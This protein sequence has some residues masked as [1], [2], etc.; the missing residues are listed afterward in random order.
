MADEIVTR[1][2]LVDAGLDAESLQTFISGSDIEDVLTRLGKIYPT[3]AKLI[4][5]LMETGGW[6]AYETEAI[7]LAATPLVNPSV[8]YAFDTKKLYLWNGTIWKD[9]GLS[10][11]DL[12][13]E[14]ANANP[15]FKPVNLTADIDLNTIKKSGIYLAQNTVPSLA[16]NYPTT[17]AGTFLAYEVYTGTTGTLIPQIYI[18]FDG[19]MYA[20]GTTDI[21][22]NVYTSWRKVGQNDP[23]VLPNNTDIRTITKTGL[24]LIYSDPTT[25]TTTSNLP[26]AGEQYYV[27][28][29]YSTS[30]R[31]MVAYSRSGNDVYIAWYWG[32][33]GW[34]AWDRLVTEKDIDSL[35]TPHISYLFHSDLMNPFKETRIKLIGDSITWG[36][37]GSAGGPTTPRNGD[38]NDVRNPIDTSISKTWANLFR[39]W[40]AKTYGDTTVTQDKPG[41]GF[42]V[43]KIR[44]TWSDTYKIVKMTDRT[45][46]IL[47]DA[48]KLSYIVY[49]SEFTLKFHGSSIRLVNPVVV[50]PRPT[51]ME[52][53]FYGDNIAI[54]YET[55]PEGDAA[56]IVQVYL[57]GNLHGTFN[58]FSATAADATYSLTTTS[59]QHTLKLKNIATNVNSYTN[60]YGFTIDKK[61]YV[62]NDGIIGTSTKNWIDKSL[63]EGSLHPK[64]DFVFHMLGT[65]DRATGGSLDGYKRRIRVGMDKIKT[66]APNAKIILMA[67]TY[68]DNESEGTYKF[69]MKQVS[70]VNAVLAKEM[71]VPFIDHYKYCAQHILDGEVI[72][73]DGTHLNDLG[74]R[75]F[76]QNILREIFKI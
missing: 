4:R 31:R 55:R 75:L 1:Q 5:I 57:D 3:L 70:D 60:I 43:N 69:H 63:Y 58:Y 67:S 35:K 71:N 54:D 73:S 44:T 16:K 20:R 27:N 52:V 15:L 8:G 53:S 9:E 45:G 2:Q 46:S 62:G 6:K 74:N 19:E 66:L 51:E 76:F 28:V 26:K 41:S 37:G 7:L 23:E 61:I 49:D 12:A 72:L 48:L 38:L 10:P 56:D 64:D 25:P 18:T 17:K 14:F 30:V 68:A 24:Y 36:M 29:M 65:N 42:T 47:S 32:T 13:K 39:T 34:S 50:T 21:N 22:G 11:L 33:F 40:I 59:G